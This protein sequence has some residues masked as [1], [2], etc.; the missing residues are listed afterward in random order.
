MLFYEKITDEK[1]EDQNFLLKE[2]EI[3][4]ILSCLEESNQQNYFGTPD[5]DNPYGSQ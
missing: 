1:V 5:L 3:L 2:K 4:N